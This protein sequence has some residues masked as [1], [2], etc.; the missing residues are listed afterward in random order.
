[1]ALL[2]CCATCNI[3]YSRSSVS[4]LKCC[5]LS[6]KEFV[7]AILAGNGMQAWFRSCPFRCP[8]I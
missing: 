8:P 4:T 7:L 6:G 1:M 2:F 3:N 5:L